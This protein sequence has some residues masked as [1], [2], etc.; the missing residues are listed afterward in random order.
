M[1]WPVQDIPVACTLGADD[2]QERLARIAALG[3][4]LLTQRQEGGEL[5]LAYMP[6]AAG[7]LRE[8]VALERECCAFLAFQL[9]EADGRVQL[10]ITA[11]PESGDAAHFLFGHFATPGTQAAARG[12]GSACGCR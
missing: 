8:I 1:S 7:E 4:H 10:R 5:F 11:P 12:C 2:L 6:E 9:T 3:Q